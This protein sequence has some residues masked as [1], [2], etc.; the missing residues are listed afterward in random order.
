MGAAD[1]GSA[2]NMPSAQLSIPSDTVSSL[3]A[4]PTTPASPRS[5]GARAGEAQTS[6]HGPRVL[7][8]SY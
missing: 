3:A 5:A 8:R 6:E 1:S 4:P 2:P 7:R